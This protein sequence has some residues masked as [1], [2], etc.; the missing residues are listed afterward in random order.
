MSL[1]RECDPMKNMKCAFK[2][3][4]AWSTPIGNQHHY[5]HGQ[6]TNQNVSRMKNKTLNHHT[7]N[8]NIL[9]K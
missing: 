9:E 4:H 3:E 1:N 5:H 2:N 6:Q 7:I 8:Q